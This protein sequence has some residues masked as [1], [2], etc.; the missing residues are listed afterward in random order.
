[1]PDDG[2][3]DEDAEHAGEQGGGQMGDKRNRTVQR[4]VSAGTG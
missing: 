2:D 1:M 4:A 3:V